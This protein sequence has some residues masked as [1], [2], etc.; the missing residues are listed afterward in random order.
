MIAAMDFELG[1]SGGKFWL[2]L[3][4]MGSLRNVSGSEYEYDMMLML[5]QESPA[6]R[7]KI[8]SSFPFTAT[9]CMMNRS[10]FSIELTKISLSKE[11][12]APPLVA[13]STFRTLQ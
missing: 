2:E 4:Q 8:S 12:L 11:W 9:W 3:P 10:R 7:S 1:N 5:E 13:T 6:H